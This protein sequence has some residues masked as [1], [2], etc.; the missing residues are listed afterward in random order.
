MVSDPHE[1]I[2]FLPGYTLQE[3]VF[4][5]DA[6]QV[7]RALRDEDGAPVIL[8]SLRSGRQ[9][10]ESVAALQHEYEVVQRLQAR[11]VIRMHALEWWQGLPVI[12]ME[13][14]GGESLEEVAARR[15]LTL[16]EVLEVGV[17]VAA[18]IAEIHAGNII[19]KDINPS[20]IIYNERTGVVRIIDFNIA[21]SLAQEQAEIGSIQ[22]TPGT[23]EYMAPEQTGRMNRSVDY[24]ADLY[25][26]GA[27]LYELLTGQ[28]LFDVKEP[29]EWFHSH[30]ARRPLPPV[31]VAA[32]IP[33]PVSSLIMKLLEKTAEDRYQ[34]ARGVGLDLER[35]LEQLRRQKRITAFPLASDDVSGQFRIPQRPYGRD[36]ELGKLLSVF[37]RIRTGRT[38]LVLVD[39]PI[40][41]GKS[42]L[43]DEIYKSVAAQRG[44]LIRGRFDPARSGIPYSALKDALRELVRQL[45]TESDEQ[46]AVWRH[47]LV[48]LLGTNAQLMIDL[49]SALELIIGPQAA[50]PVLP[51]IESERRF[52]LT[53]QG[54][55]RGL[56][57]PDHPLVLVL[58]NL[59][60]ADTASLR[61]LEMLTGEAE[62]GHLLLIGTYNSQEVT[63][64]HVLSEALRRLSEVG[65]DVHEI[66]LQPLRVE[67]LELLLADTLQASPDAVRPLAGVIAQ[68]TAGNLF[69]AE[70][71]LWVLRQRGFIDFDPTQGCW[72]WDL[73]RIRAQQ[74]TDN[75]VELMRDRLQRLPREPL[76]L[77]QL[78]A[79][80]GSRFSTSILAATAD[81]APSSLA[82]GLHEAV[83]EGLVMTV[84]GGHQLFELKQAGD[85]A[86]LDIEFC[87][88]HDRVQQT[89]YRMLSESERLVAHRRIGQ[90]LQSTLSPVDRNEHLFELVRHLNIAAESMESSGE[91]MMLCRLNL[92]AG[93][94]AKWAGSYQAAFGYFEKALALLEPGSWRNRYALALELHTEAA[95]AA[96][97]SSNFDALEQWLQTGLTHAR[98]LLDK[99][100]L[101]QVRIS[102]LIARGELQQA[103]D[104][105]RP[106]LA[107]LGHVYPAR[108][109]PLHVLIKLIALRYRLRGKSMDDIRKLPAMTDPKHLAAMAIGERLG[110]AAMFAQP[111]LLPLMILH[112][113]SVSLEHGNAPQTH[114]T[115]AAY[116]MILAGVLGYV[117]RG[118]KFGRLALEL[119][120]NSQ[121]QRRAGRTLHVYSSLVQ[122][123][124]EPLRN[125]LKPL[126]EAQ[127]LCLDNGDFEYGIHAASIYVKNALAAGV[128]LQ[129]LQAEVQGLLASFRPLRQEALL[130]H[131]QGFQQYILNLRG[132]TD[133]PA[134]LVGSAYDIDV[135]LSRHEQASDRTIVHTARFLQM[136]LQYLFGEHAQALAQA[137][138]LR[139]QQKNVQGFYTTITFLFID[140]LSLAAV[141]GERT[142]R[143]G[144]GRLLRLLKRNRSRLRKL[145]RQ[146]PANCQNKYLLIQAEWLRVHGRDFK[147]HAFY[148]RSIAS[149]RQEG[150]LQEQALAN[151]LCGRMH[152]RGGRATLAEPYLQE[153][154]RLYGRWG[155]VAKVRDLE[156]CFPQLV[157]SLQERGSWRTGT[158]VYE[159]V[160]IT[161]LMKA[162]KVIANER[163]HSRMVAAIIK[164]AVEFAAAQYGA[165][166]LRNV[167]GELCIEAE[168]EV[169]TAEVRVLQSQPLAQSQAVSQAVVNYVVRTQESLVV[170]DALIT[171]SRIPGLNLDER[172]RRQ[173]VRSIL[174][175]PIMVEANGQTELIGLLYLENNRA[176]KSFTSERFGMLEIICLAA[177][178]RLELSRK[179]AVD[180]LTGLF[181]HDYFQSMLK[182]E[183]AAATRHQ[184]ELALILLDI[185]HFKKF[186]DT[187][188]HQAGD[189][190][191]REVADLIKSGLREGDT[192]ARYGGEEFAVILPGAQSD[193]AQMVAERLRKRIEERV[194]VLES[195]E[196]VNTT[197]S[198]GVANLGQLAPDA[199]RLV[200]RA[201]EALYRSKADGRNRLT[202]A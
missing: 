135:M 173:Q 172:V 55:L 117:D 92:A 125:T 63:A 140:A 143:K 176:S 160:N 79:C 7:L 94:R 102:A 47:R 108:P 159:D 145:A 12:V 52:L 115:Y 22:A 86:E 3:A 184:R 123:W 29:I 97:L 25:S 109:G 202:V 189:H 158:A 75:V 15:Q 174:C 82:D 26:F 105:A 193:E 197:V 81:A 83:M 188:G 149:A 200:R 53:L 68:K 138:I 87:F 69:F 17:E 91:R 50:V 34:S 121:E 146:N 196:V 99:T 76:R 20:N 62:K 57:C 6:V 183:V 32:A 180:G 33:V 74:V 95:E 71:F 187:W 54:L 182:Q 61:L 170:D 113:V 72:K 104:L 181:N 73:D 171:D 100:A 101:Y 98:D 41:S 90:A 48:E 168:E 164:A 111:K 89:A 144:R 49:V 177:A 38:S 153:A 120:E 24:R 129:Q 103:V 51:P 185:D 31:A 162:L 190:V 66:A 37:E 186:N 56:G 134:R 16:K 201:D 60:Y 136:F 150:V 155:A 141:L 1:H 44:F 14:I 122:H 127:K 126:Q 70:E 11:R 42:R 175:L 178:G 43:I 40:G 166:V 116:G 23:L 67:D 21:T 156:A 165:L 64:A 58:H 93:K 133:H 106:V 39:G 118:V 77:L 35:C 151:E 85:T 36:R 10:R 4:E 46:I 169:D 195:D 84:G 152:M 27:T 88:S 78:A 191:L 128:D 132:E 130:Y 124:K 198:L 131:L 8:K 30:I 13:D 59:Q 194:I 157:G 28:R 192:A 139:R 137:Q 142:H 9:T 199:V 19:H 112:G 167:Q 96:Y 107:E 5:S 18:G 65:A 45:L 154:C 114:G 119:C 110:S 163:V 147:A 80:I 161:S 2:D 148:D 179:A